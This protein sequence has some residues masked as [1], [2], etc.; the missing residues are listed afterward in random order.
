[1]DKPKTMMESG[2]EDARL[3]VVG[4][5][6]YQDTPS[7]LEHFL[8]HA[9]N[10]LMLMMPDVSCKEDPDAVMV[11][12]LN[13]ERGY[14]PAGHIARELTGVAH[15]FISQCG[16]SPAYIWVEGAAEGHTTLVAWPWTNKGIQKKITKNMSFAAPNI[17]SYRTKPKDTC[18][19]L[20]K[21]VIGNGS[22]E[23][24]RI[25]CNLLYRAAVYYPAEYGPSARYMAE[26]TRIRYRRAVADDSLEADSSKS[27]GQRITAAIEAGINDA[28]FK[29]GKDYGLIRFA[30]QTIG[31]SFGSTDSFVKML[32]GLG[33][34]T[35][36][37]RS[38]IERGYNPICGSFPDI[39]FA[40]CNDMTECIRRKNLIRLVIGTYNK[41]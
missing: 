36:A 38:T 26:A 3:L 32:K 5:R 16:N 20:A 31:F 18:L 24:Q 29:G 19:D 23:E 17:E 14:I 10:S 2:E 12:Y 22:A 30:M 37:A 41:K 21:W 13:P 11:Y 15:D 9:R 33:F 40:D 25:F 28:H 8:Q 34:G 39:S 7:A 35:V 1:M 6:Y 27:R 4:T